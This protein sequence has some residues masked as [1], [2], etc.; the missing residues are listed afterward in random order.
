LSPKIAYPAT[1]PQILPNHLE[2]FRRQQSK[3]DWKKERRR[4][5]INT[6]IAVS[7]GSP[8]QEKKLT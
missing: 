1:R 7:S 5:K 4:R 3:S 8:K 6:P 2:A